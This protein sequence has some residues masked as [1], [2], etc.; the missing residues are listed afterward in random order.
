MEYRSMST[1]S[2]VLARN[3]DLA[4]KINDEARRDSHSPYK[5]KYVG[6]A[7]GQIVV[8]ADNWDEVARSL[9]QAEPDLRKTFC[10]EASRNYD[11]VQEIW[12]M[13]SCLG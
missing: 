6:I 4:R 3:R 5:G 1:L 9:R 12:E 2:D 11:E 8:V 7:N 10:L 13:P